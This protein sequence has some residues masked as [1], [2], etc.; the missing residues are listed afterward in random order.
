MEPRYAA[1][2][3]FRLTVVLVF[4]LLAAAPLAEARVSISSLQ[5]RLSQLEQA[6][7]DA[8]AG[9]LII[10]S[11]FAESAQAGA[12]VV[13]TGVNFD[14]GSDL[15][16]TLGG[17]ELL[18]PLV[19]ADGT[20]CVAE[21]PTGFSPGNYNLTF[22]TGATRQQFDAAMVTIGA[23]GER[24]EEGAQGPEGPQG[25]TGPEGPQ[26]P[27]GATGNQGETGPAGPVGPPGPPGSD[28]ILF[29]AGLSCPSG[30]FVSGFGTEGQL[31][32]SGSG[33]ICGNGTT[34]TGEAC[35]DG[36]LTDG[37]GCSAICQ[38]EVLPPIDIIVVSDNSGSFLTKIP[39]VSS[40]LPNLRNSLMQNGLDAHITF[41]S[42]Q[43]LGCV[44]APLG[45]GS[46][47]SDSNPP[48]YQRV[49]E[50]VSSGGLFDAVLDTYPI[51]ENRMR[52]GAQVHFIFATDDDDSMDYS[53]FDARLRAVFGTASSEGYTA[54]AIIGLSSG[55]CSIS[56]QG[57]RYFAAASATDGV[58]GD[59]CS[60]TYD[61]FFEQV[62]G[63]ILRLAD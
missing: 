21:L 4:S 31:I 54:H 49:D 28:A 43:G 62:I 18:D 23:V 46:C 35:D 59:V 14:N 61:A 44:S 5:S 57:V 30:Q 38:I 34:E 1:L 51:Y 27:A 9:Q 60:D 15:V 52:P 63:T 11:F 6:D 37:D 25:P 3:S 13:L 10:D 2:R 17:I 41:V 22:S 32:C 53:D 45:N 7:R 16:L 58:V 47:P 36:N 56:A 40:Q 8:D 55:S 33:S 42:A 19:T 20:R 26:G 29:L 24:G 48:V 12:V 39:L 50:Q